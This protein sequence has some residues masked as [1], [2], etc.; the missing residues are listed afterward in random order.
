MRTPAKIQLLSLLLLL[1]AVF[2]VQG[3]GVS[4]SYFLP[5]D[6]VF[7]HPV[8]PLSLRDIG[9]DIGRYLGVAGS[10]SLYSI[11]GMGIKDEAGEPIDSGGPLVGP[12]LSVLSSAVGKIVV[13]LE[14]LEFELSGGIFGCYNF[15]P[16]LL[17][18]TL[19][20]Y[21]ATADGNTYDSV[22]S[23]VR[24]GGRWGWGWVFGGKATYF[25]K[26]QI[27]IALGANYYLGGGELKL[28]GS[29]DGYEDGVGY[30]TAADLPAILRTARLDY[31]GLEIILGL[32]IEF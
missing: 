26:G 23:S 10:L 19:D 16:P 8:P 4:F 2:T 30:D 25:L 3:I 22:T 11:R 5:R 12:F 6:G 17:A 27:G 14:Q 21:L 20:R 1:L 18:G 24:I 32:D 29:Y 15:D 13:P 31:T 7:S 28:S 9:I